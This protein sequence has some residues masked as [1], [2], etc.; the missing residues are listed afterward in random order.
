ML[1]RIEGKK[2]YLTSLS[3]AADA[4]YELLRQDPAVQ[5]HIQTAQ[6]V[7]LGGHDKIKLR[8]FT[9][10][11]KPNV[12]LALQ[13]ILHNCAFIASSPAVLR[14]SD[15]ER[16]DYVG[17]PMDRNQFVQDRSYGHLTFEAFTGMIYAMAIAMPPS[18]CPPEAQRPWL[19]YVHP[20]ISATNGMRTR[21]APEPDFRTWMLH[22]GLIFPGHPYKRKSRWPRAR[23]SLLWLRVN[24]Q[25]PDFHEDDPRRPISRALQD[26]EVI[27]P[28]VNAQLSGLD[29]ACRLPNYQ[30]YEQHYDFKKGCSKLRLSGSKQLYRVFSY[31]DSRGGRLYGPWVQGVP[32][33]LRRY[34]TINGRPVVELDYV[35]MQLV[36][37]YAMQGL[38]VSK[39]DPYEIP[40]QHRDIMKQVLTVSVGARTKAKALS[41]IRK[42]L[43]DNNMSRY[44]PGDAER[45]YGVFWDHHSAV[46]PHKLIYPSNTVKNQIW[47]ELQYADSQIALRVLRYLLGQE[48][49]TIPIH[50]SFVVQEQHA[51][52]L[53]AA[54]MQAFHD[55]W[56]A[57]NVS[58]KKAS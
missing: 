6:T 36:L 13:H 2:G 48:I 20:K 10:K 38:A 31:D 30:T 51:L 16:W 11:T 26:D 57:T 21:I 22:A 47:A 53:E 43:L 12:L 41:A 40:G 19:E 17:V 27:L 5:E 9:A 37:L 7:V 4:L 28:A 35:S 25:D 46:C 29:I 33:T 8:P 1:Q 23:T 42:K 15:L 3:Q 52:Q 49:P 24:P 58:I 54:M 18:A 56:P 34:L 45:Y 44:R 50:D 14:G 39:D 32:S 55:F